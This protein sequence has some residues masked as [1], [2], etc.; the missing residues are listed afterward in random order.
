MK[1]RWFLL[2][3]TWVPLTQAQVPALDGA[4]RAVL[5]ARGKV[6][7]TQVKGEPASDAVIF[8]QVGSDVAQQLL[9]EVANQG[10]Q[11]TATIDDWADMHRAYH[12]LTALEVFRKN[13]AKAGAYAFFN[14]ATK[15]GQCPK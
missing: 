10:L 3:V 9:Q 12:G 11:T 4:A 15:T 13:P 5:L 2:V 7:L 1:A 14:N 8:R 6:L